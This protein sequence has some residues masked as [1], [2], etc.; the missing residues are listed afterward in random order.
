M[1]D[2]TKMLR[3][4][5]GIA[6]RAA[7]ILALIAMS[8]FGSFSPNVSAH[9][10]KTY[11]ISESGSFFSGIQQTGVYGPV[12]FDL[13][14]TSGKGG[15]LGQTSTQARFV[16]DYVFSANPDSDSG[17]DPTVMHVKCVDFVNPANTSNFVLRA[18]ISGN[19][20]FG[21]A[22]CGLLSTNK[23]NDAT[24]EFKL[25]I[26]GTITGGTVKFAGATGTFDIES[27]GATLPGPGGYFGYVV[28]EGTIIIN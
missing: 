14:I 17:T 27:K 11:N 2:F 10:P 26:V 20:L 5:L 18:G 16:W 6:V 19:L 7:V 21:Q 3:S 8:P 25:H 28:S 12:T 9:G 4:V 22:S 13:A 15:G 1:K 24:G 23:F